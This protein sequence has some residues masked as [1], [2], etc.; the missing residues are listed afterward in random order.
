LK[1][2]PEERL[3]KEERKIFKSLLY[4]IIENEINTIN[5]VSLKYPEKITIRNSENRVMSVSYKD[6]EIPSWKIEIAEFMVYSTLNILV[7]T[8]R[9]ELAHLI[10][11]E[12]IGYDGKYHNNEHF[13]NICKILN[14]YPNTNSKMYINDYNKILNN[15]DNNIKLIYQLGEIKDV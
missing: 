3:N 15:I 10:L 7:K 13:K 2:F 6:I 4:N 14:T 9:H 8:F 12:T 1:L 5:F 11:I